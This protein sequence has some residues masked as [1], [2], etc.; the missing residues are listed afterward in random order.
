MA[1][2][3]KFDKDTVKGASLQVTSQIQSLVASPGSY[4]DDRLEM[5]QSIKRRLAESPSTIR[6]LIRKDPK[7]GKPGKAS[8]FLVEAERLEAQ[9][10]KIATDAAYLRS[11]ATWLDETFPAPSAGE[12]SVEVSESDAAADESTVEAYGAAQS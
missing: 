4:D 10:A 8:G 2:A 6:D 5:L 7:P 3:S 9:A 11:L 1:R 12:A